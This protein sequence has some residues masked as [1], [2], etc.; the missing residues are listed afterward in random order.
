MNAEVRIEQRCPYVGLQPFEEA[1]R[2]F[3]FGRERDQR[4]IIANLLSSPLTILYGSSGV[5]KS[6][7][8]MAGVV[9]QLHRERPRTP[10]VVFRNWVDRDFQLALTRACIETVWAMQ[11]DQ[12]RPAETL[13][14]DEVL[15][16]CAEAAHGTILVIFDQFEEYFLYHA[17][18]SEAAGAFEAQFA[19]AVNRED[20]D[21]GFLVA[22]RDDSLSRLDR[23]QERIH[24]L[25]SNRL[26][27]NHLEPEAAGDAI[28]KPLE[29]WNAL[30]AVG[31][32]PVGIDDELVDELLRQVRI[33]QV[34]AGRPGGSGGLRHDEGCIEAPF[35]QLVMVRLWEEERA[36]GSD[37]LRRETLDRLKGADEIVRT[38]LDVAMARLDA[39]SQAVCASFFDRLVTPSGS[40]IACGAADLISWAG[41]LAPHVPAVLQSLSDARNRIL[42]TVSVP[43]NPEVMR[44]EIYHDVLAPAILDWRQRFEADRQRED[45]VKAA[46]MKVAQQVRRRWFAGLVMLSCVTAA[47]AFVYANWQLQRSEANEK[48]AQSISNAP[49]DAARALDLALDAVEATVPSGMSVARAARL[50]LTPTAAAEDALRQAIQASRLV[51]TLPVS[52]KALS[53]VAFSPDGGR[54]LT[55][56]QDQTA[57]VWDIRSG[58]PAEPVVT[59]AHDA[60]VR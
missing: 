49:F 19:R 45:A 21:V 43:D 2:A 22:L 48:A 24:N 4:V 46:G 10:V 37:R 34:S 1:D 3:F 5:G 36:Q 8:L 39:T 41:D 20:V 25:L 13:P 52:G 40:K 58:R 7:V 57:R 18:D 26:R 59:F 32:P 33:G 11:V 27:L 23:F 30:Q 16:A 28:R 56:G 47:G 6:S 55:A 35:L 29:V 54:L 15:R 14:L 51:W 42:R 17:K 53:D 60:W 9:P 38:H 50:H 31:V 44:Y 12:P